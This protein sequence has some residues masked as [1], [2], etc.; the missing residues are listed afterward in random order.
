[1]RAPALVVLVSGLLFAVPAQAADGETCLGRPATIVDLDGGRVD[2]TSGDDV[3]VAGRDTEVHADTGDDTVCLEQGVVDGGD[4]FDAVLVP[5]SA[6]DDG[7]GVLGAEALDIRLGGGSDR[8]RLVVTDQASGKIVG[9]AGRDSLDLLSQES[10]R[11]DLPRNALTVDADS[12]LYLGGFESLGVGSPD[13]TLLGTPGPD[14]LHVYY[15]AC[16]VTIKGGAGR[17]RLGLVSS[18]DSLQSPD[19]GETHTSRLLGQGG[20]DL[21]K[22]HAY[23]DRLYGGPGRDRADGGH[24]GDDVCRA[25]VRVRC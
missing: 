11:A 20:N 4:G 24:G 9:G 3:I 8:L 10:V 7:L 15:R 25:E 6:G 13:V 22:G 5:G 16:R 19:C 21:L 14:V 17:D 12:E 1:V 2:G 18:G 23:D